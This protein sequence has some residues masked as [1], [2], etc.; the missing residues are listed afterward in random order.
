MQL[1]FLSV[2]LAFI[3]AV[4]YL[5]VT[6]TVYCDFISLDSNVELKIINIY[7]S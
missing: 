5:F 3:A 7:L 2:A 6:V 4:L 1:A